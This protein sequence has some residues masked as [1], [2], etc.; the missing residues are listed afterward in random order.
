MKIIGTTTT[1]IEADILLDGLREVELALEFF[2]ASNLFPDNS[3][4][5][6]SF[7][8][9]LPEFLRD[10]QRIG[11]RRQSNILSTTFAGIGPI[12]VE[13]F[14]S[15]KY[16]LRFDGESKADLTDGL[17]RQINAERALVGIEVRIE[18]E[19]EN[20]VFE[21]PMYEIVTRLRSAGFGT[22]DNILATRIINSQVLRFEEGNA[23]SN[24]GFALRLYS[25]DY[26]QIC[27]TVDPGSVPSPVSREV[28]EISLRQTDRDIHDSTSLPVQFE[29]KNNPRLL[30][31]IN[32]HHGG[33]E[34]QRHLVYDRAD[35]EVI[36]RYARAISS[37]FT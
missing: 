23:V 36:Y 37:T 28:H 1:V 7:Y 19:P 2:A 13:K 33:K 18:T 11:K 22:P 10:L 15:G 6:N 25:I 32:P 20:G 35:K 17:A 14:P 8:Q 21:F 12:T 3:N 31:T 16:G 30:I 34:P 5:R 24:E 27:L 4:V 9:K 26:V 29:P